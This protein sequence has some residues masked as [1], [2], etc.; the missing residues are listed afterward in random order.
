MEQ[1]EKCKLSL[2][3]PK[4]FLRQVATQPRASPPLCR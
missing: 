4:R 2:L 3:L 1:M